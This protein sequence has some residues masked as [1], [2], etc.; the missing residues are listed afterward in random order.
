MGWHV[1]EIIIYTGSTS[2]RRKIT[3]LAL[4]SDCNKK[5]IAKLADTDM[6]AASIKQETAALRQ[7]AKTPLAN[8]VP[9]F[10]TE[11]EFGPYFV[12]LQSCLP[13]VA[14]QCSYLSVSHLSFLALLSE[15]NRVSIPINK[16]MEWNFINDTDN[17]PNPINNIL[18]ILKRYNNSGDRIDCHMIHGDFAPWNI[19]VEK[20]GILVY[21]WEESVPLGLPFYDAFHFIYRQAT[22]IGPWKGAAIVL[23]KM[24][25]AAKFLQ[26][27]SDIKC[28]INIA[29]SIWC[30]K[31]YMRSPDTRLIEMASR[32]SRLANE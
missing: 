19:I 16:T 10:I 30:I 23:N 12:Q 24:K 4:S 18:S 29:L 8:V 9:S 5:I 31:E 13:K 3:L 7:L 20:S 27:T 1:S 25:E 32:I 11:E 26:Y 17:L 6:A 22:L 2:A 15:I 21:D 28:D 14:S